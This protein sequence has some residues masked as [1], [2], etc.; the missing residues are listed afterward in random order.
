M[1][2]NFISDL[3]ARRRRAYFIPRTLKKING[4]VPLDIIQVKLLFEKN[5]NSPCVS[6]VSVKS[7][8]II[9]VY[10]N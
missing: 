4:W 8:R 1:Q 2:H 3:P 9:N 10:L 6:R 7:S 5:I